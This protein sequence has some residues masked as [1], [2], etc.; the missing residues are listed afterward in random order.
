MTTVRDMGTNP[1]ELLARVRSMPAAPRV[2][3]MQLVAGRRFFFNGFRGVSTARGTVYR[4][5][6]ALT[7]QR[8]GWKPIQFTPPT[9]PT[10]SWMRRIQAGAMG[11]KL[12]AHL[13]TAVGAAPDRGGAPG[14]HAGVGS[15]VGPA[16]QRAGTGAGRAGWRGAR[17]RLGGR[18]LLRG[19][20]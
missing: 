17:G 19:R 13:D 9:I 18:A 11:L 16:G 6:P 3:A 14:G 8:L 4:Q 12:Y 20:A 15:R 1:A 5:P 7:M 2:Y 10:A